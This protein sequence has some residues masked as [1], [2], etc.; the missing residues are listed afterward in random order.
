MSAWAWARSDERSVFRMP[1]LR[2]VF[3]AVKSAIDW[4]A[5]AHIREQPAV[6]LGRSAVRGEAEAVCEQ[7]AADLAGALEQIRSAT[8]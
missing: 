6:V 4:T 3:V 2:V 1:G 7:W 5:G 8:S